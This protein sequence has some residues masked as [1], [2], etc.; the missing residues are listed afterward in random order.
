MQIA[1]AAEEQASVTEEINQNVIRIQRV[2]ENTTEGASLGSQNSHELA[3]LSS[4]LLTLIGQLKVQDA[5]KR[6][7]K[8]ILLNGPIFS[9]AQKYLA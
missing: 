6:A 1:S 3:G 2:S 5:A 8:T 9:P 4:K 7:A